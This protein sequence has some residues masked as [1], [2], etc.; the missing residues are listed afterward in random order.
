MVENPFYKKA[1]ADEI[2]ENLDAAAEKA[3]DAE[4]VIELP[5]KGEEPEK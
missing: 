4:D 5:D 2:N 3:I 1:K